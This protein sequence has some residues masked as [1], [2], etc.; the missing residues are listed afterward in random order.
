MSYNFNR[1]SS[2]SQCEYAGCLMRCQPNTA[3]CPSHQFNASRSP[4][5]SSSLSDFDDDELIEA[6]NNHSISPSYPRDS[7]RMTNTNNMFDPRLMKPDGLENR[8]L[9]RKSFLPDSITSPTLPLSPKKTNL[10]AQNS[11]R[12]LVGEEEPMS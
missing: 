3:F 12:R 1:P 2:P 8:D 5:P 7:G 10:L 6:F 9:K 11:K 4:S